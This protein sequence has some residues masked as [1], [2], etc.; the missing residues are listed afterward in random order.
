MTDFFD[1]YTLR[2]AKTSPSNANTS[3]PADS[4]VARDVAAPNVSL[5]PAGQPNLVEVRADQYRVAVLESPLGGAQEFL[6]WA[7][8]TGTLTTLEGAAWATTDGAGVIPQGSLPVLDTGSPTGQSTDGSARVVVTDNG[9]RDLAGVVSITVVRGDSPTVYTLTLAGGDFSFV[10]GSGAIKLLPTANTLAATQPVSSTDPALSK[11]RGDRV[12]GISY[13]VSAARFWWT[14]NDSYARRFGWNGAT[15][16]WEPYR[17]SSPTSLGKLSSDGRSYTLNPRPTTP[18]GTMI[19]GSDL[20]DAYAMVRLGPSPDAVSYPVA[21]R[22]TGDYTGILVVPDDLANTGYDFASVSPPLAGV[23]GSGAGK[24][25]WNPAFIQDYEGLDVWYIPRSFA[26]KSSGVIGKLIDAQAKDLFLAPVPGPGERPIVRL[27]NRQSLTVLPFDT[28]SD[29]LAATV[30]EGEVGFSISTGRIKLAAAD[31]LKADPGTRAVPNPSFDKLYLGAVI[32]Y[33]GVSLNLYPQPVKAPV[34]L[35]DSAGVPVTSYNPAQEVFIPDAE[36]LPAL[37]DSGILQVPDGLGNPPVLGVVAPR[38][39]DSGLVRRLSSGIGDAILFTEGR[40]VTN[41]VPVS[42]EDELPK[43]PFRIK[44][45]TAYV[46]LEKRAGA[47]SLVLFGSVPRKQLTGKPVYFRQGE[48]VPSGYADRARLV[49]R[50]QDTFVLDGTERLYFK[51]GVTDVTWTATAGTWTAIDVAA[52]IYTAILAAGAQGSSYALSG[53]VVIAAKNIATGFV[54]IGFGTGGILDLSGCRALG[55]IPGWL[56]SAVRDQ[57]ATDHNWLPD[58]GGE[59]GFYR[60]PRDLD[61]SQGVPDYRDKYRLTKR[62]LTE[63]ISP[64]P[65]QFLDFAPREDIAGYDEGVFFTLSAAGAPGVAPVINMPLLPWADVQ[66]RFEEKKFAWLTSGGA[67]GQVLAPV[68]G[69]NLGFP[70]VLSDSLIAP[71]NGF[72]RVSEGGAFQYLEPGIDFILLGDGSTGEAVLIRR[73]GEFKLS[74]ARGRFTAG[75]NTLTDAAADFSSVSAGDRI[76]LVSGDAQG[77]YIVTGVPSSTSLTVSPYF[78]ASDAGKN[79]SYNI[80]QGVAPGE[81]DPAIVADVTYREFNHLADEPFEIRVLT[82]LGVAGGTLAPA[83]AAKDITRARPIF[84][85]ISQTGTDQPLVVLTRSELGAIANSSLSVPATGTRFTAG[86][87]N[88]RI[89]TQDFVQ[90]AEVLPVAAFSPN[91]VSVEYLTTGL[92]AGDLKFNSALLDEYQTATVTYVETLLPASD[93]YSGQAEIDPD[94][95][96]I[97]LSQV[98]LTAGAGKPVYFIEQLSVEG[99][100]DVTANPILGS[101][102]FLANPIKA[103]QLVEAVYFRAVAHTGELY[104]D[105]N[106]NPVQVREFLPLYIRAEVATRISSQLF[107]FNPTGRTVDQLVDTVVYTGTTM[108]SYGVPKGCDVDF[109]YNTISIHTEVPSTTKVTISYAVYEAFGGETSYT[110]SLPPVWRPPFRLDKNQAQFLLDTDRTAEITTGKVLRVGSFTTYIRNTSYDS[111]SNTT[112]VTIF[113]VT[114]QGAGSLNPGVNALALLSDRPVAITVDPFGTFP[115]PVLSSDPGFLPTMAQAFNLVSTPRFEPV[116]KNQVEIKFDGDLTQYAVA[117]HLLELFGKPFV[118]VKA[119]LSSDGRVTTITVGSAFPEGFTW[120]ATM[121]TTAVRI[122]VRPIYPEGATQFLGASGYLTTEPYEVVLFGELDKSGNV[123][124]G[125]TLTQGQDYNSSEGNGNLSFIEPHQPGFAADQKLL[126]ARTDTRQIGPFISKGQVQYPR[127]SSSF[128]FVDSPSNQNGRL[129]GILQGTYTF[130][131]PDAFYVRAVPFQTYVGEVALE[132]Q[133]AASAQEPSNGPT[134]STGAS[135]SNAVYGRVGLVSESQNLV[136]RDRAARA[137]LGFYNAVVSSFEQIEE[138]LSGALVGE[139]DGKLRLYVGKNDP[140]T[141]PGYEDEITGA[142]NPRVLWFDAWMSSR[143]GLPTIRLIA[144]D[145]VTNPLN[146]TTDVNGR[147]VGSYQDP[148]G[149]NALT[150]YQTVLIKNDVDD[151]VLVTRTKVQRQLSGFIHFK[152]TAHGKFSQLSEAN[153]FSRLFPER[154]TGFTTLGPGLDADETTGDPGLYTAG[155]FGFDPLGFL[156]GSFFS[157]RSTTDT[158]IGTL[159]NPVLGTIQNV[160]GVKAHARLARARI[161]AYSPTGF[162]EVEVLSA[163]LPSFIAT[164][165]PLVDFPILSDTGLPDTSKLASQSLTPI[166]TGANDLLTGDPDLHTPSFEVGAQLA[167]GY[168]EGNATELGYSDPATTIIVGTSLRYAGVFVDQILKGCII[169]LKSKDTTGADFPVTNP[170]F[171]LALTGP[172][173]G[174]P[175]AAVRGDTVFVVPGTG[176]VLPVTADPPTIAELQ[177]FT[178]ALPTYRTGTDFNYTPRTGELTDATLPSFSDPTLFGLKEITGQRPPAPLSTLEARV[179]FQNGEQLPTR[180]PALDGGVTLDSGDY[181]LPYYGAPASELEI[182]SDTAAL[183]T[184]LIR[185]DSPVSPLVPP[186]EV[187]LYVTEAVYPDET[188]GSDGIISR[189]PARLAQ[190]TTLENLMR[191]SSSGAYPPPPGHAGVGDVAVYDLVLV[192]APAT[193]T[194]GPAGFYQG[195]TG[196]HSVASLHITTPNLIEFPRFVAPFR[197]GTSND[198]YIENAISWLD[199]AHLTGML[200]QQD[201]TLPLAIETVFDVSSVGSANI[202]FDDGTGGGLLPIPIGG[203][204]DVFAL[205]Q[206]GSQLIIR[207]VQKST[208]KFVAGQ[209]VIIEK[210]GAGYTASCGGFPVNVNPGGFFFRPDQIVIQ[211]DATFFDFSPFLP[212]VVSPSITKTGGFHDFAVSVRCIKSETGYVNND[213]LRFMD[214][215]DFRSA[216]PRGAVTPGGDSIQCELST[217][218]F[219]APVVDTV[220]STLVLRENLVN[221]IMHVNASVPFTFPARTGLPTSVNGVG[222]FV[223]N[224]GWVQTLGLEGYGN[225]PI[226]ATGLTFTAIPSSRQDE[227][228]PIY[229]GLMI[230]GEKVGIGG[231]SFLDQNMFYPFGSTSYTGDLSRILPG[232]IAVIQRAITP[233]ILPVENSSGKIGTYLVRAAVAPTPP[234]LGHQL[235]LSA[236]LGSTG[237]WL[238]FS[239]PEVVGLVGLDL[240]VTSVLPLI[241]LQDVLGTV[242][243]VAS[244]FPATG[245][246]FIILDATAVGLASSAVSANYALLDI[247]GNRF[248]GLL[249]Y[250][251]GVGGAIT[252]AQFLASITVGQKVSG[253]TILPVA[254]YSDEVPANLPGYTFTSPPGLEHYFGFR[255]VTANRLAPIT[256]DA[257][258]LGPLPRLLGVPPALGQISVYSKVKVPSTTFLQLEEPVYDNIA[259]ALDLTEFNWADIHGFGPAC[260]LP[261]DTWTLEYHAR[262]GIFIEPSFPVSGNDLAR[263]TANV[264]DATHSLALKEIGSRD[265]SSYILSPAPAGG[266]FLEFAQVEVCR[267]RRFHPL[268]NELVT[269]FTRLRFAYEIRRGIVA[270]FTSTGN[271]GRLTAKPVSNAIM[272]IPVSGGTSTQLGDFNLKE[273]G[274]RSGDQIRFL[275]ALGNVVSEAEILVV[276]A[277]GKTLILSKNALQGVVASTTRF[278]IYLRTPLIP[279]EQSNAELLALVTDKLLLDRRANMST[280]EGGK[281]DYITDP[282]LQTAYSLSINKLSDTDSAIDFAVLGIQAGDVLII[283]PAR[284]LRGPTGPTTPPEMGAR[285]FGDDGVQARGLPVYAP[286]SP[287]RTDD[288]RGYYKVQGVTS[289]Q[290]EVVPLGGTLAGGLGTDVVFDS[291]YAVYPTVHG[292]NLSGVGDGEEGQMDLRPTAFADGSGSF[293]GDYLS[294]APFSYRVIRPTAFLSE[295]TVELILATRERMLSWIEELQGLFEIE[296]S[297]TYFVFQ[298]DEH[299]SD[300]GDPADPSTGLGVLFDAY[301][302]G[303]EGRVLVSPFANTTDCLSI[304]DRRFWG[305][306]FRLDYLQPPYHPIDPSYSDFAN[307]VGRPVLPDRI[308][309]ALQQ[310]DRLRDSRWAW[311]TLRTDRVTG[312]LE[313]IRRFERELPR[314][315]AVHERVLTMVKG[316]QTR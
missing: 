49:S 86:A 64:V 212:I 207:M 173:A 128:L 243:P 125:R 43:D 162:P 224:L 245:R 283:D 271:T 2:G 215:I 186:P 74:G 229:N 253:M 172:L 225:L 286:G 147:P 84:A 272:P 104:L 222:T 190:L 96:S 126:F 77:S 159:E 249:G 83:D 254:P 103:F 67:T 275:D 101:F 174:D 198:Y 316:V 255:A 276:E 230:V 24:I 247:P 127:T 107:S 54:S 163:G 204:N 166:P 202:V 52:S 6:V 259:G 92:N 232:D 79:V 55:F 81:V 312:T 70:G 237:D 73:V 93:L 179:S 164:P 153:S 28:E 109:V 226:E 141:P 22:T 197:P 234:R 35:V 295:E 142:L 231:T 11:T 301:I 268:L 47:G 38:P 15:S 117:G 221:D 138:N 40:S 124:P 208:G 122:S 209:P 240:Y 178:K 151:V 192:Q 287:S 307:G 273:L 56:T 26:E 297:G 201:T 37:G 108:Q 308:E 282:D 302:E 80:Y 50:L 51:L 256:Y 298:R 100:T 269:A 171:L 284:E 184:D 119:E 21:A 69:L 113:P 277:D 200:V 87:F 16:K 210:T 185:A 188:L 145:H 9:G 246:V 292:S 315:R 140:W 62:N 248:I 36:S 25:I 156:F 134:L 106:G 71:L 187:D 296:K 160:L 110:V 143:R 211:T 306:D 196:I 261:G 161:W 65:F 131:S 150:N 17:G 228:G 129:G 13:W 167:L 176:S 60:S 218:Q 75:S 152:V 105:K 304:L 115:V 149:F 288:N 270:T 206:K 102:T 263:A 30:S 257:N 10:P 66:Y 99:T 59:F 199:P 94:T 285:P 238:D 76:K 227:L 194:P 41:I 195:V 293:R 251:D 157:S 216:L 120:A 114:T 170:A 112:R 165:L 98:D 14:R 144:T 7:A 299:I 168:P 193:G 137:F 280:Q 177:S 205:N 260:L 139:R 95:G 289:T 23:I 182:L 300:L 130:E 279:Q 250:Q 181:S 91:P 33:D 123:L 235:D 305:L 213:R 19:P 48:F 29:L 45:N 133:A 154:T 158:V 313:A 264:V 135:K 278:E 265:I 27:G 82:K 191:G 244:S 303:L 310:R 4:G 175:V 274:I 183:I 169:T 217:Y 146:T 189:D 136:D 97:A 311:L 72:L 180:I 8:N 219:E 233:A 236:T 90:G 1:G 267:I 78:L 63:S 309:E 266:S 18:V 3:A 242:V 61:G 258:S 291:L 89:G 281:V 68:A 203:L 118:I 121:L 294:I 241:P 53:R 220:T 148:S 20:G 262:E 85:R 214:R 290:L 5:Y 42:F 58:Y 111:V 12:T 46:A 314:R 252:M 34:L 132:I 39:G 223:S 32:R 116:T 31:V 57:S 239:F 44:G 88:L 155:K